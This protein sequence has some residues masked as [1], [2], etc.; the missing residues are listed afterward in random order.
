MFKAL[1]GLGNPG[2]E[3]QRTYHNV[4]VVVAREIARLAKAD[5]EMPH[6]FLVYEPESF[7]NLSGPAIE[8][9]MKYK[10]LKLSDILVIHDETD[11]LVGS[12]K[13]A[14]DGGSAGHNGINSLVATFKTEL[15][16]RLRIGVRD[17]AEQVRK[18]A[19]EFVL[20][21]YSAADEKAF[22]EI[23]QKAWQELKRV[24]L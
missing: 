17:P 19:G 20:A 9:W 1:V 3:Y 8:S 5:S 15:F 11:L 13:I 22:L 14:A 4:G 12:Y 6:D 24:A 10:N 16:A 23:A 18:K 2:K 7:M 21:P